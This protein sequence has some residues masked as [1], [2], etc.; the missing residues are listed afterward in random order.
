MGRTG[1]GPDADGRRHR[2]PRLRNDGQRKRENGWRQI[3]RAAFQDE[4]Q[5]A[6]VIVMDARHVRRAGIRRARGGECLI[7]REGM[8]VY[9]SDERLEDERGREQRGDRRPPASCPATDQIEAQR[10]AAG[11]ARPVWCTS[12][13]TAE[14]SAGTS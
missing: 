8:N 12:L 4:T 9:R 6:V 2:E 1:D 3:S 13:T 11:V 10:T 14:S 5:R 7:T